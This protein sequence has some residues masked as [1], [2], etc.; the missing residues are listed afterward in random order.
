MTALD[1]GVIETEPSMA[2]ERRLE[3]IHHALGELIDWHEP[4]AFAVEDIFF[5]RNVRSAIAVGQARGVALLAAAQHGVPC[6]DYTPQAV[7]MAG[8]RLRRR[9]QA[10]GAADGRR[11][12]S[13]CR[14]P[15]E[16]DHAADALAVAICHAGHGTR[17]SQRARGRRRWRAGA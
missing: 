15:P 5:G 11:R 3:R 10:P 13:A 2:A 14:E 9:R 16:S 17:R 7:K 12:C 1:G 4:E 8:L 6:F